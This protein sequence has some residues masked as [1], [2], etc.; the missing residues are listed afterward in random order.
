MPGNDY[1]A[2][3]LPDLIRP[4]PLDSAARPRDA[5]TGAP[6]PWSAQV[7]VDGRLRD[8]RY[9]RRF[10]NPPYRGPIPGRGSFDL[11]DIE[12]DLQLPEGQ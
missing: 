12:D 11:A 5:R 8:G 4:E 3:P 10:D 2:I 1:R 6:V 7:W 9:P